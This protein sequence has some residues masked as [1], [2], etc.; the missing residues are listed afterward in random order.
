MF[1]IHDTFMQKTNKQTKNNNHNQTTNIHNRTIYEITHNI[2]IPFN[3]SL[4][5]KK[6]K[7]FWSNG[8]FCQIIQM[9][10]FTYIVQVKRVN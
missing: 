2:K 4:I 3:N 5:L 8:D 10:N 9:S 7:T 6:K 1:I